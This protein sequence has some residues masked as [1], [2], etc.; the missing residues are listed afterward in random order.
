MKVQLLKN[1]S[2]D[3]EINKNITLIDSTECYLLEGCSVQTPIIRLEVSH[4]TALLFNY[5]YIE[6]FKRYYYIVDIV[7]NNEYMAT[8]SL[9]CDVLMSFKDSIYKQSGLIARQ[10][11]NYNK[12]LFDSLLKQNSSPYIITKKFSGGFSNNYSYI[13]ITAGSNKNILGE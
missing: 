5:I 10:E 11:F 12:M 6:D 13:L 3:K 2:D 8:L 9:K 1:T 4:D 7:W